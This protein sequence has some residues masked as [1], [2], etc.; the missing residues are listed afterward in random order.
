MKIVFFTLLFVGAGHAV[1][2]SDILNTPIRLIADYLG[3]NQLHTR[4]DEMVNNTIE[5]R[6]QLLAVKDLTDSL[7]TCAISL[8]HVCHNESTGKPDV[9][10]FK[11][12]AINLGKEKSRLG[13]TLGG[14]KGLIIGI[15]GKA[16]KYVEVDVVVKNLAHAEKDLAG[17][18]RKGSSLTDYIPVADAMEALFG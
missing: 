15:F 16:V 7:V 9:R 18:I 11:N 6:R 4:L 2:L 12:E 3:L 10:S 1:S 14:L 8:S 13:A 17:T 5:I